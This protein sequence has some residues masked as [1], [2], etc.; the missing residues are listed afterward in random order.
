MGGEKCI[1]GVR[2]GLTYW[3]L[4]LLSARFKD[5]GGDDGGGDNDLLLLLMMIMIMVVM[6]MMMMTKQDSVVRAACYTNIRPVTCPLP[7]QLRK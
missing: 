7:F 4:F 1:L 6:V 2:M 5:D 3:V